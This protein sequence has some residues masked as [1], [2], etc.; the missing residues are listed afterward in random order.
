MAAA[1]AAERNAIPVKNDEQVFWAKKLE[2]EFDYFI[3]K[4]IAER[5]HSKEDLIPLLQ[6]EIRDLRDRIERK[7][8]SYDFLNKDELKKE[9]VCS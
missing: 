9:L 7:G 1:E 3:N 6:S 2:E 5:I 8:K 4:G